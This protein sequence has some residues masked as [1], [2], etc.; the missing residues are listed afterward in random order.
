M[1]RGFQPP[2]TL[3]PNDHHL[4]AQLFRP[5]RLTL[6]RELRKL[7]KAE[8][9]ERVARTPSAMSQFESGRIKPD[10]RTV[11]ELALALGVPAGFFAKEL[12][13]GVL[14]VESCH[15]RSL[16]SATQRDRRYLL[17]VGTLLCELA[18]VLEEYAAIPAEQIPRLDRAVAS[19]G[20]VERAADEVRRAW[21]LGP[22]PI[23]NVVWLLEGRGAI[24]TYIS[25]ECSE[26]DA[27][28][29]WRAG[30]G[31]QRPFLFLSDGKGA[32]A[33]SRFDAAHELGHLVMHV[34]AQPGNPELERQ[35][36]LFASAFLMPSES[37]IREA[38]RWLNWELIWELKRRWRVS[39]RAIVRR[40]RDLGVLSEASYRRAFVYLNQH[41]G[42]AE[43]D[44][45]NRE[46][47]VVLGQAL[48]IAEEESSRADIATLLGVRP[49][50]LEGLL[51][52]A[53]P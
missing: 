25:N 29:G 15:F 47:P 42:T 48:Q 16:R 43:P 14:S 6:A 32:P 49:Q 26:V 30:S 37:F 45:P 44:E 33:R 12:A 19:D 7:T 13:A 24:V 9:A 50:D 46:F 31:K 18:D 4:A 1:T 17:S 34:D 53:A 21:A 40:S 52:R 28:S 35:A 3:G 22:G 2:L 36:N 41:F 38:P 27:F 8:L 51:L 20:D 23:S 11:G 39:A 10:G 5:E